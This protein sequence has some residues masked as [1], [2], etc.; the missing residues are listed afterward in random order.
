MGVIVLLFL[1]L[2]L[3]N[4][5]LLQSLKKRLCCGIKDGGISERRVFKYYMVKVWLKVCLT[6]LWIF[7]FVKIVSMGSRIG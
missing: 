2:E 5:E 1:I 6:S 7:I 4:K 3:K